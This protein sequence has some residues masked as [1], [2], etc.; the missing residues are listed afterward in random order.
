MASIA[1]S[2]TGGGIGSTLIVG[3][4]GGP[5]GHPIRGEVDRF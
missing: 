5:I 3:M 4:I 2:G 1:L